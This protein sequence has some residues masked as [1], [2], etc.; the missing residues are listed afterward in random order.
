MCFHCFTLQSTEGEKV[1]LGSLTQDNFD[2]K[3]A[4]LSGMSEP[5]KPVISL[6]FVWEVN[7]ECGPQNPS[8]TLITSLN[9]GDQLAL[10]RRRPTCFSILIKP[11][12]WL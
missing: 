12:R 3:D 1:L 6:P 8:S 9:G 7:W 4:P 5:I 2:I 10:L 11:H